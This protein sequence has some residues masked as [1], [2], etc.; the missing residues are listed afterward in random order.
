M[1]EFNI[2]IH[3]EQRLAYIPK[4]IFAVLSSHVKAI[5]NRVAVL[6]FSEDVSTDDVLK[7]LDIIKADLLHAQEL[8]KRKET[9][10]NE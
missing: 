4:E 9:S 5:P 10:V 2:K 7:S 1:V 3:P 8:E 6:I